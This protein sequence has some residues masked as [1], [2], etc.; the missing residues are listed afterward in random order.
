MAWSQ[1]TVAIK[2]IGILSQESSAVPK[3][4][5]ISNNAVW[6]DFRDRQQSGEFLGT[7]GREAAGWGVQ[8]RRLCLIREGGLGLV[9]LPQAALVWALGISRWRVCRLSEQPLFSQGEC[10]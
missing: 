7:A 4:N 5:F 9:P 2:A 10:P 8:N 6:P 1:E 3:A